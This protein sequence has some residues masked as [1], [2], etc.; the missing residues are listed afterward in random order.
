M[1]IPTV[2]ITAN[3]ELIEARAEPIRLD[4]VEITARDDRVSIVARVRMP[5]T[6]GSS[7][8]NIYH[9]LF[10]F[11]G[12]KICN[13]KELFDALVVSETS[14]DPAAPRERADRHLPA[15]IQAHL[16]RA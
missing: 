9:C 2:Y 7:Y 16:C 12:S 5:H 1:A 15:L 13:V 11:R 10:T 8:D 6:K 4:Y 3:T 14:Q